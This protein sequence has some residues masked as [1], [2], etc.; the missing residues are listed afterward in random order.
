MSRLYMQRVRYDFLIADSFATQAEAHLAAGDLD[1]AKIGL[2]RAEGGYA[3]IWRFYPKLENADERN[4]IEA[5]LNQ[6]RVRL[7]ALDRK[8]HNPDE[9]WPIETTSSA[10]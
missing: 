9:P 3:T 7:D 1:A 8:L 2:K 10:S 6:F 4:E 5:R